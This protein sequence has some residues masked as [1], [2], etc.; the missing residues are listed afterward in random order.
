LA[1]RDWQ[2]DD[3]WFCSE[4]V[5]FALYIAGLFVNELAPYKHKVT[6]QNIF[7]ILKEIG[8]IEVIK[9]IA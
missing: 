8:V 2:E 3:S 7:V 4:L 9:G 6:P 1:D 5:A